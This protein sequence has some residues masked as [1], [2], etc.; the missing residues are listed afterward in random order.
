M[1]TQVEALGEKRVEA[2]EKFNRAISDNS[3]KNNP[4]AYAYEIAPAFVAFGDKQKALDWLEKAEAANNHSFNFIEVDPR[5]DSLHAE[6]RFE[7]LSKK[8]RTPRNK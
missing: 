4:Q 3:V 2:I 6:P 8:L 7:A 5:L 1:Q